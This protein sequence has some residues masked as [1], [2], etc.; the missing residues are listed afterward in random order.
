MNNVSLVT[1]VLSS[2][3]VP[4]SN[5][6]IA[7]VTVNGDSTLNSRLDK[8]EIKLDSNSIQQL[9]TI[10]DL[11]PD[12]MGQLD[13]KEVAHNLCAAQAKISSIESTF[14]PIST[15]GMYGISSSNIIAFPAIEVK[16][17][18]PEPSMLESGISPVQSV[19]YSMRC[20][21]V[22]DIMVLLLLLSYSLKSD[23]KELTNAFMAKWDFAFPFPHL[24]SPNII[25][26]ELISPKLSQQIVKIRDSTLIPDPPYCL[27]N[28]IFD[29]RR[30][31]W[32]YPV[33]ESVPGYAY[34]AFTHTAR[35]FIPHRHQLLFD[36]GSTSHFT[37]QRSLLAERHKI[38]STK[39]R[40]LIG[41]RQ[42]N[43]SGSM[44]ISSR[45]K[46][47]DVKFI[48]KSVLSILSISQ[49]CNSGCQVLFTK[50]GGYVLDPGTF[51]FD[52][53]QSNVVLQARRVNDLYVHDIESFTPDPSPVDSID[54]DEDFSDD[55]S[56]SSNSD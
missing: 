5:P 25:G 55:Q 52:Q 49:V 24:D 2:L 3:S 41:E 1:L 7:P 37:G 12:C 23:L 43:L 56:S 28:N 10:R 42:T 45:V 53:Y 13:L 30:L 33:I 46:L 47:K 39:V 6:A 18:V 19:K 38:C 54:S 48:P 15:S 44:N 27:V 16:N 40:T 35:G 50:D 36:S 17:K 51:S 29:D 4:I 22:Q 32:N 14:N 9:L 34:V 11:E 31:N 21:K 20:F 8:I 26:R